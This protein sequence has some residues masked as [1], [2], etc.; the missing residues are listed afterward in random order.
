MRNHTKRKWTVPHLDLPEVHGLADELVVLGQLL[1]RG[2]LD[3]DL[4]QLAAV[5]EET[6]ELC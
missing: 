3:E 5:T 6:G 2:Q 4:T 1:A